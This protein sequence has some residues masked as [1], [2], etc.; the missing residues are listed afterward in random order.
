MSKGKKEFVW[1]LAW[2]NSIM[3]NIRLIIWKVKSSFPAVG[4]CH[5]ERQ[6]GE[7]SIILLMEFRQS[8]FI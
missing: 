6:N 2:G 3:V 1:L 7:K 8:L 4:G 5:R